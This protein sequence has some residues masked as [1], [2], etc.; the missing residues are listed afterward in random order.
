MIW[1]V[2]GVRV[3]HWTD[4]VARTGC[5]VVLFDPPVVASGEVRGGAPATRE[6][7]L[8]DPLATVE[9]IDA[10]TLSGGSAFGLAAT[11]GVMRFCEARG[12]GVPTRAG[13]VP[14][15]VGMSLFDLA[16]GDAAVRPGPEEGYAACTAA[17]S[18]ELGPVGAGVGATVSSWRGSAAATPGGLV[19]AVVRRGGLV[20]AGLVAVNAWGDVRGHRAERLPWPDLPATSGAVFG[21]P[22]AREHTTI[23]VVATNAALDKVGCHH[24]ARGA[25]DGLARALTPPHARSDGDAFVAVA[26][27]AVPAPVDLVRALAVE[28]VDDAIRSLPDHPGPDGSGSDGR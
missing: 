23:G 6:F 10:V 22:P 11:D 28:V 18:S 27:G 7:A 3:G 25:H 21:A 13:R 9:R 15:V 8:L 12:R 1:E 2:P 26:T 14:I 20:V 24:V 5:T 19:G 17:G 4:P 16:V